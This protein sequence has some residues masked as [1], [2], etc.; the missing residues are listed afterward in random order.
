MYYQFKQI[1]QDDDENNEINLKEIIGIHLDTSS[2]NCL[3]TND[4]ILKC[5]NKLKNAKS[6]GADKILNE[7]IKSINIREC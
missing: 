6:K 3:F 1:S 7:D 2:L 4:D 5:I